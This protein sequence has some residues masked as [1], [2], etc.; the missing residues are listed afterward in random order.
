MFNEYKAY[1]YVK[2]VA[3]NDWNGLIGTVVQSEQGY[4]QIFCVQ[5]AANIYLVNENNIGDIEPYAA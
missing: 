3:E 4:L 2:I 1:D 5:K